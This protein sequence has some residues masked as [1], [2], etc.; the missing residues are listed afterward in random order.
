MQWME[1]LMLT[2]GVALI[3]TMICTGSAPRPFRL[4]RQG[5]NSDGTRLTVFLACLTANREKC[6][7][8]RRFLGS[9]VYTC[10]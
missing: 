4:S 1:I 8:D 9:V 2:V 5:R 7:A 10:R 3:V 6:P